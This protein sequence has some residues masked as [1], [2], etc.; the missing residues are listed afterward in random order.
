M[1]LLC[2]ISSILSDTPGVYILWYGSEITRD[3][4]KWPKTETHQWV[5]IKVRNVRKHLA[6]AT[7]KVKVAFNA[8]AVK[9]SFT[10]LKLAWTKYI[11]KSWD[12]SLSLFGA[13][14]IVMWW[15]KQCSRLASTIWKCSCI[16]PK[17]IW[18]RTPKTINIRQTNISKLWQWCSL[19][20]KEKN[21][22]VKD[23]GI[24]LQKTMAAMESERDSIEK[25][26]QNFNRIVTYAKC[27][28]EESSCHR[29][30]KN[31]KLTNESSWKHHAYRHHY[32]RQNEYPG[33]RPGSMKKVPG[34]VPMKKIA[35]R[36]PEQ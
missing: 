29:A 20:K 21:A 28:E 4:A 27:H 36:F 15:P 31:K 32:E 19:P 14:G 12:K 8:T 24:G 13:A 10:S 33:E 9:Y 11:M 1:S 5:T 30:A 6:S 26:I 34:K 16:K 25:M 2:L 23:T 7:T 17:K 3:K 22:A 18:K 35:V